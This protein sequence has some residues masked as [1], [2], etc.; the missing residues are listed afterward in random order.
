MGSKWMSFDIGSFTGTMTAIL[1]SGILA[2][3]FSRSLLQWI[4]GRFTKRLMNERYP[5]NIWEMVTALTRL[6]PRIVIENSLRASEGAVIER[7]FG[8]PRKFLTYDGLIFSPAQLAT[9]V[10]PEDVDVDMRITIGP[11]AKKPLSL[12]I[13]I[14]AGGMGYGIG[15]SEKAKIAIAKGTAAVGTL[16]NTGEGGFLPEERQNA[17]HL[18][19]QYHS[20]KWSKEPEILKQ[21][22]AIEIHIGQGAIAG[23]ATFIPSEYVQGRARKILKVENDDYVVI[24]SRHKDINKPQDLRKVVDHLRALTGGIPI[25]VK[26]CASAKIEADLEVA[27]FAGVDFVS[28]D[29]GQAGSKGGPPILEDDFGIPTIYAVS[30]AVHYLQKRGVKE[31]ITLLSGGGYFTPSD[32]LKA[33][34]LGVDGVYM[35]TALLWAMT[36][37]QV[38]KAV[39]WEPPTQLV[40]YPGSLT[41]QFDE[42]EAAKYLENFLTSF[43]EEMKVAILA[44]GKTS[45]HQ[46]G[47]DDLAALDELTSKITKVPLA[48]EPYIPTKEFMESLLVPSEEDSDQSMPDPSEQSNENKKKQFFLKHRNRLKTTQTRSD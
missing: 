41:A 16:T 39:P 4:I 3:I 44:L 1:F 38:T 34:A 28:I 9:L 22:D 40:F 48:Y 25:G 27:I 21:A 15:V 20:G 42:Q 14:M 30:R 2:L 11:Q 29:G 31:R 5:E 45:V 19:I 26:I 8:S 43:V 33:F 10:T 17:K 23:T 7:P 36:H 12:E 37:D 18:I 35:G 13:P 47:V 32:C 24:P 46:V 6:S